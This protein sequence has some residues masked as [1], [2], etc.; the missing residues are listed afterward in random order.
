MPT[1]ALWHCADTGSIDLFFSPII[2]SLI[3][4]RR[5]CL[6]PYSGR[7]RFS[8]CGPGIVFGHCWY[9]TKFDLRPRRVLLS[10]CFCCFDTPVA[11]FACNGGAGQSWFSPHHRSLPSAHG[12]ALHACIPPTPSIVAL[13]HRLATDNPS[14]RS[15][16]RPKRGESAAQFRARNLPRKQWTFNRC[17]CEIKR[18]LCP[19]TDF[20]SHPEAP[21]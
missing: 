6:S 11:S 7:I 21:Y 16:L 18:I 5:V 2:V 8:N 15:P 19:V 17:A 13:S 4:F 9:F 1:S 14:P 3:L 10:P 12:H 20:F